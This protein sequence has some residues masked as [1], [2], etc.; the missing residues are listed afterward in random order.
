METRHLEVLRAVRDR[1]GVTAAAAAVHLTPSAVSQSLAAL[2]RSVG[3]TPLTERHGRGLRLTPAGH[4]LADAG[5][6]VLTALAR[7]RAAVD[8][9]AERPTGTV[10]VAL[11]AS[12][13]QMLAP[14]LLTRA[15][16]WPG[17]RVELADEDVS[18]AAYPALTAEADVVVAHRPEDGAAWPAG[19]VVTPLLREPMDVALPLDHPLA[20]R[21][22]LTPADLVDEAWVAVQEGFPVAGVLAAVEAAAGA[23]VRVVQRSNDFHVVE[24]L[25][26]AG[27]GVSLLPRY[28]SGLAAAG[29]F[30]LVP[31][32]GV[33]AA[34]RVDALQRP[35]RAQR[36]VVA[37]VLA[38]LVETARGVDVGSLGR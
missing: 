13:A 27:H 23:P 30:A 26:A 1:G 38:A 7:A 24:A 15:A 6:D 14:G 31:L 5:A 37:L 36:R 29:R 19:L 28:T 3:P 32:V 21:T 2:Q 35:D 11:F 33:R 10:R 34:R 18:Q 8:A 25:V 4:A 22:A 17:V 16:T 9:F 20:G 12:A